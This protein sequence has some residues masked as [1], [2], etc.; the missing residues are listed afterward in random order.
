MPL[1][2]LTLFEF[3]D[4]SWAPAS[5]REYILESVTC[6]LDWGRSVAGLVGPL[7]DFV[8]QSGARELLDLGAGVGG[9]ARSLTRAF[10][11]AGRVPPRF[12]LTDLNPAP[13]AWQ[14]LAA[15]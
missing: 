6:S 12:I 10:R 1:P 3:N 7:G 15:Q 14:A 2:R 8:T 9:P 4:S 13:A 11:R 5:L